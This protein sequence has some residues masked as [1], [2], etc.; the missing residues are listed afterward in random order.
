MCT[1]FF[2]IQIVNRLSGHQMTLS[3]LSLQ[4]FALNAPRIGIISHNKE[5]LASLGGMFVLSLIILNF[6]SHGSQTLLRLSFNSLV[7]TGHWDP[8]ASSFSK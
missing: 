4:N 7:G 3:F 2:E 1:Y 8:S 5:G 6:A